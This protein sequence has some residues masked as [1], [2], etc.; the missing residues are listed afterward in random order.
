VKF[1]IA[2]LHV[3]VLACSAEWAD[4]RPASPP[5][6]V[7][8]CELAKHPDSFTGKTIRLRALY[9]Y[10]FEVQMLKSPVCCPLPEPKRGRL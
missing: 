10:A 9:V 2:I 1:Y 4:D 8:Y 7:T 5:L 3:V 6:D